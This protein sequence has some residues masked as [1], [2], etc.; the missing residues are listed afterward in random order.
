MEGADNQLNGLY[1]IMR[2]SLLVIVVLCCLHGFT[3]AQVV[4]CD[5]RSIRIKKFSVDSSFTYN[6][7]YVQAEAMPNIK[8][9]KYDL[10]IRIYA[11][12]GFGNVLLVTIKGDKNGISGNSGLIFVSLAKYAIRK[13]IVSSD[14]KM[15]TTWVPVRNKKKYD[16]SFIDSLIENDFFVMP[17]SRK[18]E[19]KRTS[20]M[21]SDSEVQYKFEIKVGKKVRNFQYFDDEKYDDQ[22]EGRAAKI[23]AVIKCLTP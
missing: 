2:K 18:E 7:E 21:I 19:F 9:S 4:K 22:V 11:F 15:A 23:K 5:N 17:S 10:E 1:I 16:C 14:G 13:D 3:I 12:S 6:N 8:D 20:R